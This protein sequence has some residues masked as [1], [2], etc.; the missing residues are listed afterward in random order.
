MYV[1]NEGDEERYRALDATGDRRAYR[2]TY[3]GEWAGAEQPVTPTLTPLSVERG[4][5]V[6]ATTTLGVPARATRAQASVVTEAETVRYDVGRV[7]GPVT[8]NWTV[9]ADGVAVTNHDD[10]GSARLSAGV[11][12]VTLLV[13]FVDP[14]GTTVTYRQT[15]SVERTGGT[16]RVIWPPETRVCALTTDCGREGLYVG[17]DGDYISGVSVE[18]AA[19]GTATEAS[20]VS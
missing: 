20:A 17:P 5:R 8:V 10:G 9:G 7:D 19:T 14:Q 13:T 2:F 1:L 16:V 11:S 15:A 6:A 4:E 12:E 18:T 3:R